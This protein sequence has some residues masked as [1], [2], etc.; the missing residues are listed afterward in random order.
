MDG[1]QLSGLRLQEM[2][3]VGEIPKAEGTIAHGVSVRGYGIF[4]VL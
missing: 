1:R 3:H 4:V 2:C